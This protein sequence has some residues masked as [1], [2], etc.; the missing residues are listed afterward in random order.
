MCPGGFYG[1]TGST[2]WSMFHVNLRR[3]WVL[4]W[5]AGAFGQLD[6]ISDDAILVT[7]ILTNAL[8]A[9]PINYPAVERA[10]LHPQL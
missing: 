7:C 1:Q 9:S 10:Y 4:P 5:L 2:P 3:T 8:P 6:Q